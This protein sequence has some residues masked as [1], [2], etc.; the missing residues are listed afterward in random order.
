MFQNQVSIVFVVV[1]EF[2]ADVTYLYSWEWFMVLVTQRDDKGIDP[3]F[4]AI[5]DQLCKYTCVCSINP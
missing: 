1:A 4:L 2:R 3:I 5:D